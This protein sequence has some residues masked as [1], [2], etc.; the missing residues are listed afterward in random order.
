MHSNFAIHI[1]I[2]HCIHAKRTLKPTN[3]QIL[4]ENI[5]SQSKWNSI[6]L[7]ECIDTWFVCATQWPMWLQFFVFNVS[8]FWDVFQSSLWMWTH[9]EWK[10]T[11]LP[12]W[13]KFMFHGNLPNILCRARPNVQPTFFVLYIHISC[14]NSNSSGKLLICVSISRTTWYSGLQ[15]KFY[16]PF[17]LFLVISKR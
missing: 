13:F 14:T 16:S 10:Q 8:I 3:Q 4:H 17:I 5:Y 7:F 9:F 6:N 11:S 12:L 2:V 1:G 15:S